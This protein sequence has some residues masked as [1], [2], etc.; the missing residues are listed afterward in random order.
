MDI[1]GEWGSLTAGGEIPRP[2]I[3]DGRDPGAF[4]DDGRLG[5][6]EG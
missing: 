1:R 4:G 3:G 6:L 2:K 5:D